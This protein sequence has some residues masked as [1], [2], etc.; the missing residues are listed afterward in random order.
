MNV[1]ILFFWEQIEGFCSLNNVASTAA[2]SNLEMQVQQK[3]VLVRVYSVISDL[4]WAW[5]AVE[6]GELTV[7]WTHSRA[8]SSTNTSISLLNKA[9]HE[10]RSIP[11]WSTSAPRAALEA[12]VPRAADLQR[13]MS[14]EI[15]PDP[16]TANKT[17]SENSF[18]TCP[19]A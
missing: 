4:T 18:L 15:L 12:A 17:C 8:D 1:Q 6:T 3:S 13:Q 19:L 9:P 14:A 5:A 2:E 16:D 11:S 10:H 7:V